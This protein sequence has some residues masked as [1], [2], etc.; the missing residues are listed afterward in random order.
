MVSLCHIAE[1]RKAKWA[2][3]FRS[4]SRLLF[5]KDV[6]RS[7]IVRGL[8]EG[9]TNEKSSLLSPDKVTWIV[10]IWSAFLSIGQRVKGCHLVP[11][12][13]TVAVLFAVSLASAITV[14]VVRLF[15]SPPP[16][17]LLPSTKSQYSCRQYWR[18]YCTDSAS[19][20][21]RTRRWNE[22]RRETSRAIRTSGGAPD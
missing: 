21:H 10:S 18:S 12:G 3:S 19:R 17:V 1:Q 7:T 8:R 4:F 15:S 2:M 16:P 9:K 14:V 5:C 13:Q 22:I 20:V 6:K 11:I